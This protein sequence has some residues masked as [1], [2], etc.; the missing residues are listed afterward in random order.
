MQKKAIMAR[1]I[2]G[3]PSAKKS[4]L[5]DSMTGWPL[6]MLDDIRVVPLKGKEDHTHKRERRRSNLLEEKQIGRS[7]YDD[8][9]HP[10]YRR[11]RVNMADRVHN[12]ARLV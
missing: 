3:I 1:A 7:R 6:V 8:R 9:L 5:H 10:S 2:V 4:T 11:M 12:L